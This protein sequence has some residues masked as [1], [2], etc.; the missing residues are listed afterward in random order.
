MS[1]RHSILLLLIVL[2]SCD[3]SYT[4][5]PAGYMRIDYPEKSY[6]LHAAESFYQ[7][8]IPVYAHVEIDRSRGAEPGW[9]NVVIPQ[10]NGKIHLSYKPVKDNLDLL[11]NRQPDACLQAYCEGTGDRGIPIY[12]T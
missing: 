4:P 5:K 11:Y 1:L 6:K 2:F 8:E 12:P 9:I 7:F 3:R 10:L